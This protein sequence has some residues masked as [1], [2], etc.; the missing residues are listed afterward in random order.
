MMNKWFVAS[1]IVF[2]LAV[3]NFAFGQEDQP[4]T[5][6]S[7]KQETILEPKVHSITEDKKQ[8]S[9]QMKQDALIQKGLVPTKI[10][11]PA[12][13]VDAPIAAQGLNESGE[14]TVPDNGEEV[15]WFEPGSMP[16]N[17]G[18][19][20][21][22]GHVDDYTGP[23]VF[24]RL[25]ELK[26]GDE[27]IVTGEMGETLTFIVQEVVAYPK[28]EAPLRQIFGPSNE[29][30]L[31]LLTCT[32]VYDRSIKDHEERLVVYTKLKV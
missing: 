20:I 27:V 21:L 11:I 6:Q 12:I 28:N 25:K 24:F 17:P 30:N 5:V 23:A 8:T 19:A 14:M 4:V 1:I 10:E 26:P 15:G 29:N 7:A 18:N 13:E 22:A 2:I 32:G 3:A 9:S 16:G 31:N